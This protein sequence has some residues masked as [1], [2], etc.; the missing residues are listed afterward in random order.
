VNPARWEP[1]T[2]LVVLL[3]LMAAH[4]AAVGL[5]LVLAPPA[6]F[7]F[8]GFGDL[9]DGFF[10]AQG[11]VFHVLMA[12]AYWA[13]ADRLGR[14]S[15]LVQFAIGVKLTAAVFLFGW[16]ALVGVALGIW[17]SGCV[18]LAMALGLSWA[19]RRFQ[20]EEGRS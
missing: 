10:R 2:Q 4:S 5:G 1:R 18:D 12:V 6:V 7:A 16:T 11:G 20:A 9:G 14:E 19:W 15:G 3:R 8:F 17:A 13:G